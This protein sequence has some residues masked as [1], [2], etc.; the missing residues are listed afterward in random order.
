MRRAVRGRARQPNLAGKKQLVAPKPSKKKTG[1]R[2]QPAAPKA[3]EKRQPVAPKPSKRKVKA[4]GAPGSAHD[5]ILHLVGDARE[6][7][8]EHR[9]RHPAGRGWEKSCLR[10]DYMAN[11]K[12]W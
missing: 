9:R 5:D 12:A 3:R 11:H 7:D 6:T 8:C 10:C 1:R 2:R 4:A